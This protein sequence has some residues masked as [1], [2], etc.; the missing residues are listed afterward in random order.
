MVTTLIPPCQA[1]YPIHTDVRSYVL[2]IARG[3]I[4]T[5]IKINL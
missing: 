5:A 1:A 3:D 2:A 4:E